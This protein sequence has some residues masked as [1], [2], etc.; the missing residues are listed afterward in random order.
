MHLGE[1]YFNKGS[2]KYY[3]YTKFI[4]QKYLQNPSTIIT[5]TFYRNLTYL[6]SCDSWPNNIY[7]LN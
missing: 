2:T 5:I 4:E 1:E 6:V 7:S 3:H